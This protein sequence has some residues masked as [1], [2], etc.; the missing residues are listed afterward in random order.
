MSFKSRNKNGIGL[1]KIVVFAGVYIA[2]QGLQIDGLEQSVK[3]FAL[4][5]L[6]VLFIV[7]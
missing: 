5:F 6:A 1:F 2:V 4:V 3:T 7:N